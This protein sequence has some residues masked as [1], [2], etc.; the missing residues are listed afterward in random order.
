MTLPRNAPSPLDTENAREAL[1]EAC[2]RTGR[3]AADAELIRLGSNAVFRLRHEPVIVR[4]MRSADLFMVAS[5]EVRVARWLASAGIPA[6][7]VTDGEQPILAAG[8]PV[9]FWISV[10]DAEEYG[11]P[12]EL[13]ALVRQLHALQPPADIDLPR[14]DPFDRVRD[15]ISAAVTLAPED[16]DFMRQRVD[17][18]EA[19]YAELRYALPGG[20]VHGDASVGNILR[21]RDGAAVLS[22]LDGFAT[23]CR[24]WDLVQTAM[25]F[26]RYGWHTERQY[27]EFVAAYGFDV[28]AWPGYSTLADIKETSM[29]AWL[30]QNATPGSKA[31]PELHRRLNSLRTG[32][33]RR[34]WK[35]F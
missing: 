32:T 2:A 35:P 4:V 22:D 27:A 15:R 1:A 31:E 13:G 29:V 11:N 8:R 33:G 26:D 12:A 34:D 30:S 18:L 24:E 9:T 17:T 3:D 19:A 5:R 25:Y 16:R 7:Q 14:L 28:L 6:I 20:H 21:T 10:S 23:G